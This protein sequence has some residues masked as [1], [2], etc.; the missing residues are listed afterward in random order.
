MEFSR[1]LFGPLPE[2]EQRQ[3]KLEAV[4][5]RLKPRRDANLKRRAVEEAAYLMK[6][7]GLRLTTTA[8]GTFVRLAEA[9][10]GEPS[11]IRH[12]VAQYLNPK[13]RTE[14]T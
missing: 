14:D 5:K 12:H 6:L 10:A 3:A 8:N 9:L 13:I 2:R 7:A 11:G 1:R 4:N